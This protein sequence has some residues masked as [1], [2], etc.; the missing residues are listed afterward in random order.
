MSPGAGVVRELGD[1]PT[2][3]AVGSDFEEGEV[4]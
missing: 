2:G 1:G 4:I 3:P